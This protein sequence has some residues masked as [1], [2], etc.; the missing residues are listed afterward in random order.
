MSIK[1]QTIRGA[2]WTAISNL[3]RQLLFFVLSAIL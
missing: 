1:Q 2:V 3:A